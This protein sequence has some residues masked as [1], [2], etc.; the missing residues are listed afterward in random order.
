MVSGLALGID[1][2]AHEGTLAGGGQ[3]AAVL[4]TGIDFIYPRR[5]HHLAKKIEE[6]GVILSE[7]PLGSAPVAG[8]FPR[9]NRIISGLSLS[10]LV[11]EAAIKSGSLITARYALEQNR[12]VLAV[13]GSI[14]NSQACGC[15]YLLQ[16]GAKLVMS[17]SDILEGLSPNPNPKMNNIK[18]TLGSP[19]ADFIGFELTTVDQMV[20][21]S[22]FSLEHVVSELS[23]L[24]LEGAIKAV[25]G[26]YIRCTV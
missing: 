1:A 5:H 17:C 6:Q 24:E 18:S 26:G 4:G 23:K 16:Q 22:G 2:K 15:N 11:V 19:F 21:R 14:Y 9:R 13:P 12:D 20:S 3:T 7:F 10:I 25:S 8:H